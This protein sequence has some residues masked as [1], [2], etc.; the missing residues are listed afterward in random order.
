[1]KGC[2]LFDR[3]KSRVCRGDLSTSPHNFHQSCFSHMRQH[4]FS[5]PDLI[6]ASE[7]NNTDTEGF[8]SI[9]FDLRFLAIPRSARRVFNRLRVLMCCL[10]IIV[11]IFDSHVCSLTQDRRGVV[12]FQSTYSYRSVFAVLDSLFFTRR[13]I[14]VMHSKCTKGRLISNF[15]TRRSVC[16]V[17][18]SRVPVLTPLSAVNIRYHSS[19]LKCPGI[20]AHKS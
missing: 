13:Y 3:E 16:A 17:Q 4:D 12:I 6:N 18:G 19:I 1:M 11:S 2:P 14:T 9:A 5:D 20:S 8:Y 7:L 10:Q 15:S